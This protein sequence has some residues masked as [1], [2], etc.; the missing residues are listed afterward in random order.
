VKCR[1]K[2]VLNHDGTVGVVLQYKWL[3]ILW[4]DLA[5]LSSSVNKAKYDVIDL[6]TKLAKAREEVARQEEQRKRAIEQLKQQ[7]DGGYNRAGPVFQSDQHPAALRRTFVPDPGKDFDKVIKTMTE[8]TYQD[9]DDLGI[10]WPTKEQ[11]SEDLT[12]TRTAFV[13]GKHFPVATSHWAQVFGETYDHV[14][15]FV[16]PKDRQQ[17]SN[18]SKN[19][20]GGGNQRGNN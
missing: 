6:Y 16:S 7:S 4:R 13:I 3:G 14:V 12:T 19:K 8:G 18:R 17:Q 1:Y 5:D 10:E 2:F 9:P 20:G 11:L 15:R